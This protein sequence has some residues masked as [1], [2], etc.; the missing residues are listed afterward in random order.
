MGHLVCAW[1][2]LRL[3]I[4]PAS[5]EVGVRIAVLQIKKLRLRGVTWFEDSLEWNP[6]LT[7][8]LYGCQYLG[9]SGIGRGT[10]RRRREIPASDWFFESPNSK[11]S[12]MG[13]PLMGICRRCSGFS[14]QLSFVRVVWV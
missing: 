11:R 9:G 5:L 13:F 8:S 12:L 3:F 6:G 7:Q 4:L 14:Q 1:L 2:C 10:G